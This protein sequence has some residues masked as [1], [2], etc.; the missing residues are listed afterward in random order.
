MGGAF[1]AT[2]GLVGETLRD[3][4]TADFFNAGDEAATADLFF[5][6]VIVSLSVN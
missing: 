3:A 4:T 1:L 6:S 5:G 2:T